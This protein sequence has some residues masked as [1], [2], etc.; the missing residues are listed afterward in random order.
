MALYAI[1]NMA[2]KVVNSLGHEYLKKHLSQYYLVHDLRSAGQVLLLGSY[3][4]R[5]PVNW[6][7]EQGILGS[8]TLNLE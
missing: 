3:I 2:Y 6:H 1:V 5:D 4:K 7:P 8:S